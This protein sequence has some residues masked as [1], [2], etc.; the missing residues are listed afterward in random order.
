MTNNRC[1][2]PMRNPHGMRELFNRVYN[3]FLCS[4]FGHK[5]KLVDQLHTCDGDYST[6][7]YECERCGEKDFKSRYNG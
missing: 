3:S 6:F 2:T 7:F 1:K 5:W 4:I